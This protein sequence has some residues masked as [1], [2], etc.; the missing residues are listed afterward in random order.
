[1]HL[2][3]GIWDGTTSVLSHVEKNHCVATNGLLQTGESK[4]I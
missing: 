1:M 3:K 4:G 2:V